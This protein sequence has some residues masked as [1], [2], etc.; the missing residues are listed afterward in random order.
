MLAA[1]IVIT[2]PTEMGSTSHPKSVQMWID[3]ATH[4]PRGHEKF[5]DS[6]NEA[7]WGEQGML[8]SRFKNGLREQGGVTGFDLYGG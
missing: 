4:I 2:H 8:S 5:H 1:S 6:H 3:D 7:S